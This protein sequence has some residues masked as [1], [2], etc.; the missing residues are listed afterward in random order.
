MK[1]LILLLVVFLAAYV[2][3][4]A[5]GSE[6][7]ESSIRFAKRHGVRFLTAVVVLF[8]LFIFAVQTK[9]FQLF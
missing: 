8:L 3:W 1:H 2:A 5:S 7:R 6:I 9:P 4:Q